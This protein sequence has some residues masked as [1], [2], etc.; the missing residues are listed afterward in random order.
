MILGPRRRLQCEASTRALII[1]LVIVH[2]ILVVIVFETK[3]GEKLNGAFA[4]RTHHHDGS[5]F[6]SERIVLTLVSNNLA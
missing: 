4:G 1:D 2:L 5:E 3:G 6:D